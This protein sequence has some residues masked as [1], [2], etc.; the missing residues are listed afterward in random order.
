VLTEEVPPMF[1]VVAVW[2]EAFMANINIILSMMDTIPRML[3][4]FVVLV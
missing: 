1:A 2:A 4:V 3:V